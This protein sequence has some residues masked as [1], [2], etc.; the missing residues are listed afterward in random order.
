MSKIELIR[1]TTELKDTFLAGLAEFQQ[2]GLA[3]VLDLNIDELKKD[4]EKFVASELTKRTLWTKDIPVEETEMWAVLEGQYV[5]RISIRH[6]LNADLRVM[7]G[8]IG[9]D[10]RPTYRGQ[11][12]ASSMLKLALP[13]AKQLGITEALLTCNDDNV[14]SIKVIEKNGGVLKEV[15]LQHESG[16]LK[17]YYLIPL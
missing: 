2:E 3:W 6:K 13:I 7:G 14:S 15:K 12:I 11:G 5:G 17:R 9:Y 4:F 10:T 8:H 1:P 16:P